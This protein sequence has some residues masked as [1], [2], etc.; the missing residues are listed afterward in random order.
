MNKVLLT[1]CGVINALFFAF[2]IF[3]GRMIDRMP[4][5]A[6]DYR[7]LMQALN[8]GGVLLIGYIAFAYLA[9][10][11]DLAT[12]LGRA[13]AVLAAVLYLSRAV[14][15]YVLFSHARP[16]IVAVCIVAGVLH[17][18]TLRRTPPAGI[19]G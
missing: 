17:L 4:F 7:A 18:A 15:E 14:E 2:H 16:V 5:P 13:T 11:R 10:R 3:L 8:V 12:R 9:C 6:P 19:A 1:V